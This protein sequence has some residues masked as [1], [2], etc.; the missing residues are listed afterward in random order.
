MRKDAKDGSDLVRIGIAIKPHVHTR[1]GDIL[2]MLNLDTVAGDRVTQSFLVEAI[3]STMSRSE[4][5]EIIARARGLQ[6][7]EEVIHR[8]ASADLLGMVRGKTAEQIRQMAVA[9]DQIQA[10]RSE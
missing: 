8:K 2:A 9:A 10:G 4:M 7:L 6:A 5:A 1:L 3:V